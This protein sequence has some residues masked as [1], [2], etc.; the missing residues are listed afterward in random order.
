M[1]VQT[2]FEVRGLAA[3][4]VLGPSGLDVP[5]RAPQIASTAGD[6]NVSRTPTTSDAAGPATRTP[7]ASC[8]KRAGSS[9]LGGQLPDS[10][11]VHR[12]DRHPNPPD[13]GHRSEV[14]PSERRGFPP[15]E[16]HYG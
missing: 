2:R 10:G 13:V 11:G 14:P 8:K 16:D 3:V 1:D 15:A 6:I 5:M 7:T 9:L 4:V 12:P